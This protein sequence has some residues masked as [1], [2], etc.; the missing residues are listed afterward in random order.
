[1]SKRLLFLERTVAEGSKD[2]FAHYC[3]AQ[4]YRS[5]GRTDD[6]LRT[7]TNIR[8]QHPN[9][10]ASYLMAAQLFE[11]LGRREESAEW[12]RV[13]IERAQAARDAHTVGELEALLARVAGA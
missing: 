9:Y 1:M 10:L 5:L 2:P 7:F 6:A 3:L 4:E 8:N 13:G 11:E 12:C